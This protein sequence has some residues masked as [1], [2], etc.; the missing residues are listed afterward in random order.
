[1]IEAMAMGKPVIVTQTTG[2]TDVVIHGE[3]GVVVP[4]NDPA[5]WEREL[6][7]LLDAPEERRRLGAN[8]RVW[9]EQHATLN[10]WT[11]TIA[12]SIRESCRC[13]R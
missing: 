5:A 6:R 3:N 13:A 1:M 8:A 2:Q 12:A 4:P 7:R 10:R 11:K 9:V